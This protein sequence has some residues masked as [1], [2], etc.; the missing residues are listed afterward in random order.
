MALLAQ[1][2]HAATF[3]VTNTNDS[4]AGSLRDAIT[5]A[6]ANAN[7][8]IVDIIVFNIGGG[9]PQTISP[10]SFYPN[11]TEAVTI[12]GTTQPGFLPAGVPIIELNGAA[13]GASG[14][15]LINAAASNSTIQGLVINRFGSYGIRILSGAQGNVVA[16]CFLGTDL[17][18]TLARPNGSGM[19]ISTANNYI[20]GTT[21][22]GRNI[23]SG[24]SVDGIQITGA[25]ATGNVVRGNYIGLDV[26]GSA[27]LGNTNKGVAVYNGASSNIIGGAGVGNVISGQ[28][29]TLASYG[30]GLGPSGT[31]LNR[32]EGNYIGTDATGTV[33]IGN[34]HGVVLEADTDGNTIGGTGAGDGNVISGNLSNGI[35]ISS[36]NNVVQ[37]NYIGTDVSGTIDRGNTQHGVQLTGNADGNTIG[38]PGFGNLISGN[39]LNG[40]DVVGAAVSNTIQGN[41][42]GRDVSNSVNIPNSQYGI[43]I[44]DTSFNTIGGTAA[45]AGNSIAGNGL[46]G[47]AIVGAAASNR[48]LRNS[49]FSNGG[50]GIDLADDGVTWNDLGDAD[51]PNE[52]TGQN[53]PVL[54]AVTTNGA[55]FVHIAGSLH[56]DLGDETYRVEFFAHNAPPDP[57]G[58]GEAFRYLGFQ[59]VPTVNGNGIIGVTLAAVVTAG[60][61]YVTATATDPVGNTSEF[62]ANMYAVGDIVVTT[63]A[64]TVDGTV[65]S[66]A[67]L[68]ANPGAD[69][70]ISLREAIRATNNTA[71]TDTIRFGIPLSDA[72]HV[73]YRNDAGASLTDIQPAFLADSVSPSSP[74]ITDFDVDYPGYPGGLHPE[75]VPDPAQPRAARHHR[76]GDPRCRNPA[77]LHRRGPGDRAGRLGHRRGGQRPVPDDRTEHGPRAGD[78]QLPGRRTELPRA[79]WFLDHGQLPRDG[80]Q[81]HAGRGQRVVRR[82]RHAAHRGTQHDRGKHSGRPQRHLRERG[83]RPHVHLWHPRLQLLSAGQHRAG[84]DPGQLHRHRRDG[85]GRAGRPDPGHRPRVHGRPR[86]RGRQSGRGEPHLRQRRAGHRHERQRRY[87]RW[88]RCPR[89]QQRHRGQPDRHER[90]RHRR[91]PQRRARHPDV[92]NPRALA[93]SQRQHHPGERD[94]RCDDRR[95]AWHRGLGQ[96]RQQPLRRQLHR[97]RFGRHARPGQRRQRHP[98]RGRRRSTS[99]PGTR[100]RTT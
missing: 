39:N 86:H 15:T 64:D 18:G 26:N 42:I 97:H 11:I 55:G 23:I 3:T 13:V 95:R 50:L 77:R 83:E 41:I 16:G 81:R 5:Q 62:A 100:S 94:R 45:G 89:R 59:D 85:D 35:I 99:P 43:W 20:D 24:N 29:A 82:L 12:D 49:I 60:T 8:P 79:G 1:P 75:L 71:G 65:T 72:N 90:R 57:S 66:V 21:A 67:N 91:A 37:R 17:T 40:I 33:S 88:G 70:R 84:A 68:I 58:H 6:N 36:N 48:V 87:G 22:A 92:R 73:Y 31:T 80:R 76:P 61:D 28:S 51:G 32:I 96:R 10:L 38:S 44:L 2:A 9:G 7:L 4:G 52:N 47:V 74:A 14:L 30:I 25:S 56:T 93:V 19:I 98:H 69:G 53:F 46:D 34:R 54:S 78:R 27:P 63:T